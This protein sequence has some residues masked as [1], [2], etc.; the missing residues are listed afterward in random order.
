MVTGERH[1][2][3]RVLHRHRA[4]YARIVETRFEIGI[5]VGD[6]LVVAGILI[7]GITGVCDA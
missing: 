7:R 4:V 2:L 3:E 6:W 5:A 1:Y